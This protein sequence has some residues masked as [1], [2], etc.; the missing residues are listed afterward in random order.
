MS[1]KSTR[2]SLLTGAAAALT[3]NN[4]SPIS[5]APAATGIRTGGAKTVM[6]DG[7]YRVWTKRIG[8]GETKVLTL[9]GGPGAP[10]FYLECFEDFLPPAAIELY[11]YHQLGCGFSDQPDDK[12]LWTIE[13]FREEVEQVRRALGLEQ[14]VLYGHSWGGMLAIE[15]A[16]KYQQHLAKLVISNM[17]ASVKSAEAHLAQLRATVPPEALAKIDEFEKAGKYE[18]P[19]YDALLTEH[20]YSKYICR[21]DPMP[22]P[23]ERTFRFLAKP[24]Y[25]TMQGPNEFVVT[26]NFKNWDRWADLPK[27]QTPTLVIG[28]RYDEMDA[29]DLARMARLLPNGRY[30]YCPNGSHLS[31]WDDQETYFNH[32]LGF[33]R[34]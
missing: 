33:L 8:R 20:L 29:A 32:L 34:G 14:F 15:Y 24:V 23:A 9:H 13:R 27:I 21:L 5:T 6:I 4:C 28:A 30:A 11:H 17:A 22:E 2:R 1:E 26:G 31:M 19:A 3:L 10:G 25:N 12:S 16:L 7:K 18:D